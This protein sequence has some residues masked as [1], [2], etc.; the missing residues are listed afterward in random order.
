MLLNSGLL[1]ALFTR[2]SS[3]KRPLIPRAFPEKVAIFSVLEILSL[4]PATAALNTLYCSGV[5]LFTSDTVNGIP[6]LFRKSTIAVT[7]FRFTP[8]SLA[9][10]PLNT[11][12]TLSYVKNPLPSLAL[13]TIELMYSLLSCCA[14]EERFAS[15][16][17]TSPF[18]RMNTFLTS[19]FCFLNVFHI[20][21]ISCKAC[22]VSTLDRSTPPSFQSLLV[23]LLYNVL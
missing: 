1:T 3:S 11:F 9:G 21:L 20:E 5:I 19:G 14:A 13:N 2:P 10:S 17:T 16:T 12:S 8:F 6:I 15:P 18:S 23:I 4:I 22:C 7:L